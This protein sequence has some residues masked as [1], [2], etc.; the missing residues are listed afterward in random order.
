M[1]AMKRGKREE[2]QEGREREREPF[3]QLFLENIGKKTFKSFFPAGLLSEPL[4]Y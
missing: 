2:E 4:L 1:R 3:G